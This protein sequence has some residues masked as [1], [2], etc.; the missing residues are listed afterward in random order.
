MTSLRLITDQDPDPTLDTALSTALLHRVASGEI[1]PTLRLFT[2]GRIVAFGSQDRPRPGYATAVDAVGGLGYAAVERLAGGKAAVSHEGTIAFAWSTPHSDPLSGI[3]ARFEA[4]DSI[5]VDALAHLGIVGSVGEVTGEYCPGRFSVHADG[6]KVMG[7]GQR[8]VRSAAHVGGLLVVH[9]PNLIN[10][11]LVPA[12]RALGYEWSP[13]ATGAIGG[14]I[15]DAMQA[16]TAAF[17]SA[18]HRLTASQFEP[19]TLAVAANL[20]DRHLPRIR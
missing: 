1:G 10:R 2:P 3:E 16:L 14:S 20:A 5:V 11:A 17:S 9:S 15:G 12:Y 18:G 19:G 6:R 7:V 8:L 4:L 13:D